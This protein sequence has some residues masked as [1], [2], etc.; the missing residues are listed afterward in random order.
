MGSMY[1][2]VSRCPMR[3]CERARVQKSLGMVSWMMRR[4]LL[5]IPRSLIRSHEGCLSRRGVWLEITSIWKKSDILIIQ[6]IRMTT[7]SKIQS[8]SWKAVN[9]P[10]KK[11][12]AY[13]GHTTSIPCS[14][15][16]MTKLMLMKY[17]A[18]TSWKNI[19][20]ILHCVHWIQ[21][22]LSY[23]SLL[24]WQNQIF[25]TMRKICKQ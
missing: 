22:T 4:C 6:K 3:R 14:Q 23:S 25:L 10:I 7:Y 19:I 9:H 16:Y 24:W 12:P 18:F 20:F 8:H 17:L 5:T 2:S 11:S 1:N 15:I 21:F 13:R